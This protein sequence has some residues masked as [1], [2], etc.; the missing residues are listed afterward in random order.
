MDNSIDSLIQKLYDKH[1]KSVLTKTEMAKELGVSIS[2]MTIRIAKG[3]NLP[4]YIKAD[5]PPNAAVTFPLHEVAKY[6]SRTVK[7]L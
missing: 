6:L 4:D 3:V 5:S 2:T 7:V 1:G